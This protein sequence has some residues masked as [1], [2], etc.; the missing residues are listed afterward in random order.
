MSLHSQIKPTWFT[1]RNAR[2]P[3][4]Y[5]MDRRVPLV[6][7]AILAFTAFVLVVSVSY[8]EYDISPVG[9]KYPAG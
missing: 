8:G 9:A 1:L 6:A 3:F 7:L 2:V 4:S 5:R